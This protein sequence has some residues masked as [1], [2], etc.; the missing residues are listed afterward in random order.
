LH[1]SLK[2]WHGKMF[3]LQ[4]ESKKIDSIL[5]IKEKELKTK[6]HEAS[7]ANKESEIIRKK[8]NPKKVITLYKTSLKSTKT[9]EMQLL[10]LCTKILINKDDPSKPEMEQIWKSSDLLLF[11][12]I[13]FMLD[14]ISI[15]KAAKIKE[16]VK[17]ILDVFN[18]EKAPKQQAKY[19]E[20]ILIAQWVQFAC[21]YII[22]SGIVGTLGKD[23]EKVSVLIRYKLRKQRW[24]LSFSI[25][26]LRAQA[27][28]S[29]QRKTGL[30]R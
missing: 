23:L 17:P 12:M 5:A 1:D 13:D 26:T 21:D 24:M 15:Q 2:A 4:E 27:L 16:E 14:P 20:H 7:C 30:L 19:S 8:L 6:Q 22:L 25:Y 28:T 18:A 3:D 10:T 9:E 11:K 29:T